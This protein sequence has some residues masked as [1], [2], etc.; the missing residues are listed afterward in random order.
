MNENW[1]LIL[2][3]DTS[4][5]Y[6]LAVDETTSLSVARNNSPPVLHLYNFLPCI[7]LGRYQSAEESI[8]VEAC[9]MHGLE[10]NRRH[11]GGGTVMMGPKQLALGFSIPKDYPGAGP[12]INDIFVNLSGV[13]CKALEKVGVKARFRPKNDIEVKKKKIAGLSASLEER[14]VAFFHTSLLLDFDFK[15]MLKVF[16]LPI[17]KLSDKHISCF[18]DRMTTV[19]AERKRRMDLPSFQSLVRKA[20][21]EHFDISFR[22]DTLNQWELDQLDVLLRHRYTNPEWIFSRRHPK[23]G[24]GFASVKTPGGLVELGVTLTGEVIEAAYLSGDFL[25]TGDEIN[26]VESAL[27]YCAATKTAVTKRLRNVMG[28]GTIFKVKRDTIVKLAVEAAKN[29][30]VARDN[31][32]KK[33]EQ[34]R[35]E[36]ERRKEREVEA[37]KAAYIGPATDEP[38]EEEIEAAEVSASAGKKKA[39]KAKPEKKKPAKKKPTK[40][41]EHKKKKATQKSAR[42]ARAER[43]KA[44]KVEKKA[45]K[46]KAEPKKRAASEVKKKT[47]TVPK[48]TATGRKAASAVRKPAKKSKA[49]PKK[50]KT[51]AKKKPRTSAKMKTRAGS[52]S[53]GR[54]A[55]KKKAPVKA[56]SAARKKPTPVKRAGAK[57]AKKAKPRLAT[58]KKTAKV[59]R[60]KSTVS[61]PKA[62]G[63]G[64][65]RKR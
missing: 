51:A 4:A 40:K 46:K 26:Q 44:K 7:V 62:K 49:A 3:K 57:Q 63:K 55:V 65:G 48:K 11:T 64:R 32:L 29:A 21:E 36:E 6:G 10:I 35:I 12:S 38:A 52:K 17:K 19:K 27:R 16:K 47:K 15:L 60:K 8:D 1:R 20:F 30:R 43:K 14:D 33:A 31:A 28:A 24:M 59:A 54:K 2:Q 50:T 37:M 56:K 41:D 61:K 42:E 13:L 9:R 34:A 39:A 45:G 22:I 23:V 53:A 58:G 25:S 18:T 5:A